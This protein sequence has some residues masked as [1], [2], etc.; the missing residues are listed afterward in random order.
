MTEITGTID[1][2]ILLNYRID[3]QVMQRNLPDGFKPLIFRGFAIGGICQVSLS[4]MR[5]KG[6]SICGTA[7]HNTAHRIAVV[8]SKGEGVYV[9][10]RDTD[11]WLNV[12]S[13]GRLFP[14]I[15][16]KANFRVDVDGDQYKV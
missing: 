8:T 2:R 16:Y 6:L 14:G 9:P 13:G 12:F 1:H 15:H 11:S 4:G 10:R 7:S 3:P 5:P